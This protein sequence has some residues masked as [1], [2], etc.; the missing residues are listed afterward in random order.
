MVYESH[1]LFELWLHF[2][3]SHVTVWSVLGVRLWAG[4]RWLTGGVLR[5]SSR[6]E[7]DLALCCP[8]A[9]PHP[10]AKSRQTHSDTIR[11]LRCQ[12]NSGADQRSAETTAL[13]FSL[14]HHLGLGFVSSSWISRDNV[15]VSN[16]YIHDL[17]LVTT[18]ISIN[19]EKIWTKLIRADLSMNCWSDQQS[20]S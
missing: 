6:R 19:T 9:F 14:G 17:H 8:C 13:S 5:C 18:L 7:T 1:R 16:S 12:K 2:E 10:P 4:C 15:H 3:M 11:T 20:N